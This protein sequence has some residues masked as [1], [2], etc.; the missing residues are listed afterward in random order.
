MKKLISEQ[1]L[2]EQVAQLP[3]EMTPKRDL[4]QGIEKAI[5]IT[6]Q[7]QSV[8]HKKKH[9]PMAWAASIVA[10]V[11]LSWFSFSP[12]T[13]TSPQGVDLASMMKQDF[14][15]E[16]KLMLTRFAQPEL[17]ALPSEMQK[18]LEELST[19]RKAIDKALAN[20]PNNSELLNLLR[21]TQKQ[22]LEFIKQL[23][24]PKWQTI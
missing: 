14:E 7:E 17:Q 21:W 16:K 5:A 20:D 3:K 1:V 19:A 8:G 6:P 12:Q 23:Y 18:Q 15:Q 24:S 9:L 13:T 22:E 11:L 2:E 10:A 4:W